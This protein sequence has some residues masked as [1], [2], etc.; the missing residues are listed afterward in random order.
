MKLYRNHIPLDIYMCKTK[1]RLIQQKIY[2]LQINNPAFKFHFYDD[3]DAKE[4]I[5]LNF[6]EQTMDAFESL[7]PAYKSDLWRLCILYIKGGF[8]L[9]IK[10]QVL[11]F[12]LIQ[13]SESEHFVLDR[14]RHSLHICNDFIVCKAKNPFLLKCIEKIVQNVETRYYGISHLSPTGS[15]LLGSVATTYKFTLPIHL[16]YI[17][18]H[19]IYNKRWIIK[20]EGETH[21]QKLWNNKQI[22]KP[23]FTDAEIEE[24]KK[25]TQKIRQEA[26]LENVLTT[27]V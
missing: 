18:N 24:Y 14:P 20:H 15:E 8:Y 12:K 27:L 3:N 22:Y 13:L 7:I 23:L 25:Y 11:N 16:F 10:L 9:D 6:N 19:I 21:K 1:S 2:D 26:I 4:F 17:K 5:K